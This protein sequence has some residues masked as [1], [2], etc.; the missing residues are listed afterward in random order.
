MSHS[1]AKEARAADTPLVPKPGS[2]LWL[3]VW[4]AVVRALPAARGCDAD[5]RVQKAPVTTPEPGIV[6]LGE[7]EWVTEQKARITVAIE[8]PHVMLATLIHE[9]AH[10]AQNSR[11]V[12]RDHG[13]SWRR[14]LARL[15]HDLTGYDPAADAELFRLYDE[16]GR[17][18]RPKLRP[19]RME[20]LDEAVE[21]TIAE[22]QP[23]LRRDGDMLEA[24]IGQNRFTVP[25]AVLPLTRLRK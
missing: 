23:W 15:C 6:R 19:T 21:R 16:R 3:F 14:A 9:V 17:L 18:M 22:A 2:A 12:R 1:L 11:H 25:R 7:F 10:F 24:W 4:Y 5:L 20:A 13:Y 8:R